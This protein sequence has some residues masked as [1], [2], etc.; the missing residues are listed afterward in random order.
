MS[1]K[2]KATVAP[3][4]QTSRSPAPPS[5]IPAWLPPV[6]YA[7]VTII[8]FREFFFGGARLLG[9]DTLELGYFARNFYTEFVQQFHGFP[10]WNPLLYGGLPFIDGMHGDIFYPPSLALFFMDAA[11][12]WGWKM[13]LHIFLAGCFAYIWLRSIAVSRGAALVGG[14]IYLMSPML[15]S[16]VYPGGDGKLF[17]YALAPLLFWLTERA[18]ANR[19]VRDFA[20][21]SLGVALL[22]FTSQMHVA[23]FCIWGITLYF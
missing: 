17:N 14:L 9:T 1:K 21:F 4:R 13:A 19:R 7:L 22:I 23:Y 10:V 11:T 5:E 8:L 6:V 12:M 16:M 3:K 2:T 15:V 20:A 18:A